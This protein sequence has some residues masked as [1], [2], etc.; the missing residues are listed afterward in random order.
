MRVRAFQSLPELVDCVW[1]CRL[2]SGWRAHW[3][4][5]IVNCPKV[6]FRYESCR[7]LLLRCLKI[8]CLYQSQYSYCVRIM[9]AWEEGKGSFLWKLQKHSHTF[10]P[11]WLAPP[12]DIDSVVNILRILYDYFCSSPHTS[13][14]RNFYPPKQCALHAGAVARN[15]RPASENKF[16]GP[17]TDIT[18]AL[19]FLVQ[20][21]TL[22]ASVY[23]F[24]RS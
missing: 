4:S 3:R 16:P 20:V 21:K 1:A 19:F 22:G 17:I 14:K 24:R 2:N 23:R 12:D 9:C 5:S 8:K 18:S 6:A 10:E 7:A 13:S 11:H 15:R